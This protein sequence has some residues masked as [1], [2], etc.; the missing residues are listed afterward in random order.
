MNDASPVP[1][2]RTPGLRERRRRATQRELAGAA[3]RLFE[4]QGLH[5]TTA[6][7][8]ARAAGISPRTFFRYAA[9]KEH[10]IFLG[11]DA[12][13]DLPSRVADSIRRGSR[14]VDAIE[15][16]QLETLRA[17][18]DAP[19]DRQHELLRVR[20]VILAEPSLLSLAL[21][22]DAVKVQALLDAVISEGAETDELG[23]R[24]LVTALGTTMRLAFDEWVRLTEAG[25]TASVL[26]LYRKIGRALSAYFSD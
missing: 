11:D 2:D 20:R 21:A 10:A 22:A 6:D 4:R 12:F 25:E 17:F 15:D 7:D 18:D 3:L 14:P 26:A 1:A 19:V 13:D 5:A 9:T 24:A 23:A 16:A 8:I